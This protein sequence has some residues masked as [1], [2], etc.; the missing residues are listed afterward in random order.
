MNCE[1]D[2]IDSLFYRL[3]DDQKEFKDSHGMRVIV[4]H[5]VGPS[6]DNITKGNNLNLIL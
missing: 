3:K 6:V 4:G 1:Y 2:V 5:Y